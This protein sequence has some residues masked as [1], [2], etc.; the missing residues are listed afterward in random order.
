MLL[1]MM[2]GLWSYSRGCAYVG[3]VGAHV[4]G[5]VGALCGIEREER[6]YYEDFIHVE[7]IISRSFGV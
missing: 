6:D 1:K 2:H 3:G 7:K 4:H 5:H